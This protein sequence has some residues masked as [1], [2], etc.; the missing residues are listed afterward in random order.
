MKYAS[1]I[2]NRQVLKRLCMG[3]SAVLTAVMLASC[4]S[5]QP[6]PQDQVRQRAT[7]HWQALL[8]GQYDR[9]YEFNTPAFRKLRS[10]DFYRTNRSAVPVKWISAEVLRV[11]C[12]TQ[13]CVTRIKLTSRPNMPGFNKMTLETGIDEIWILEG[14]QWWLFEKL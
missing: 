6:S 1:P 10:L 2:V 4:A 8:A 3:A 14:G 7:Q 11:E 13:R 9:A 12:E 5:W